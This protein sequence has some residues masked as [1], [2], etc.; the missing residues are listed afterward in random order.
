M[1]QLI[2]TSLILAMVVGIGITFADKDLDKG[3]G[4]PSGAHYNL[5]L[6]GMA[7]PKG[8]PEPVDPTDGLNNGHR[9]F[10]RLD[11]KTTIKLQEGPFDVI[12]YD[13]TDGTAMFQLPN[14]DVDEL[15]DDQTTESDY[16]VFIRLRGKP[17]GSI[18][19]ETVGW[20]EFGY[21]YVSAYPI[22]MTRLTGNG[23]NKFE[24]VS[25]EL[26]YIYAWIWTEV[27]PG[28]WDWEYMRLPLF[29]EVLEEYAWDY[30]NTNVR[31]AQ[32]RFYPGVRTDIPPIDPGEKPT[33]PP[34]GWEPPE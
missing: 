19:M 10:V 28:V 34:A 3:N 32:L 18:H 9:I 20:D 23:N 30:Y 17:G 33:E 13:G 2:V 31:L 21:K 12:D 7:V 24:N 11:G 25:K 26:L 1:K 16:S 14:P 5:N 4:L 22:D 29:D 27:S 6:I 8:K 15:P